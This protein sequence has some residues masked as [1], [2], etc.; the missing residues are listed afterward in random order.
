MI[1]G[2][3]TAVASSIRPSVRRLEDASHTVRL[4]SGSRLDGIRNGNS[5]KPADR[6]TPVLANP[7]SRKAARSRC[8]DAAINA[9]IAAPIART[10]ADQNSG[11]SAYDANQW[12]CRRTFFRGGLD[13][14]S[15]A[16]ADGIG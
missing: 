9:P 15:W 13:A 1:S 11:C 12:P 5:A 4:L 2:M 10:G 7:L 3:N 16:G 14:A 6:I 8:R